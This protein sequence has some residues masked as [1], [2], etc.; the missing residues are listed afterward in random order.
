MALMN[1]GLYNVAGLRGRDRMRGHKHSAVG[2][3][4]KMSG[5]GTAYGLTPF[6]SDASDVITSPITD[7]T[8]GNALTGPNTRPRFAACNIYEYVG[9]Y[10]A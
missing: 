6:G 8:N 1:D 5:S 4:Y 2:F 9:T 10:E 3:I 7:G